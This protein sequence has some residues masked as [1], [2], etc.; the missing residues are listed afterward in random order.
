VAFVGAFFALA[1]A[2]QYQWGWLVALTIPL[3]YWLGL[4]ID[5]DWDLP[6]AYTETKQRWLKIPIIGLAIY[7][8]ITL[9]GHIAQLFLGGHRSPMTH[10]PGIST[11]GR[12]L[13][14]L[15]PLVMVAYFLSPH[16]VRLL[17][18]QPQTLTI[19]F[20]LFLGVSLS[21]TIHV[22]ADIFYRRQ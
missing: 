3:G 11:I 6:R 2:Y 1:L 5:P 21:D 19:I 10:L 16:T 4:L 12:I 15:S 20:G 18:H 9:Y 7:A 22:I 17:S 8:W 14:L 13:W